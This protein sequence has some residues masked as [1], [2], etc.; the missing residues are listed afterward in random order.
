[1]CYEL[2]CVVQIINTA[3]R[4]TCIPALGSWS[5]QFPQTLRWTFLHEKLTPGKSPP[6]NKP[7]DFLKKIRQTFL[8]EK[9]RQNA[10]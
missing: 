2:T 10:S 5:A 9:S 6:R 1:M 8:G 7:L 4:E 3:H